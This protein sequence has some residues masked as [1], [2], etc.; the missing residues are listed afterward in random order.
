MALDAAS[1]SAPCLSRL[2]S[3]EPAPSAKGRKAR[4]NIVRRLD[5]EAWR[6]STKIEALLEELTACRTEVRQRGDGQQRPAGKSQLLTMFQLLTSTLPLSFLAH[7]LRPSRASCFPSLQRFL[8]SSNGG[9]SA[10]ACGTMAGAPP[11]SSPPAP[12][13]HDSLSRAPQCL[14][15]APCP[16][17][18][19][20]LDGRMQPTHRAAVIE[21]FNT[22]PEI[23]VFLISLKVGSAAI[24]AAVCPPCR[25]CHAH[26]ASPAQAGGLA[27]NLTAA[28]RVYIMDPWWNP[29]AE[30]QVPWD[31]RCPRGVLGW[32]FWP[33]GGSHRPHPLPP[34][35]LRQGYGPHPSA[36]A[37]SPSGGAA[38][39]YR[40][41]HREPH[42]PAA[43]KEAA[44]FREHGEAIDGP[45]P[46][47]FFLTHL[48]GETPFHFPTSVLR[49]A[50]WH[51]RLGLEP[52]DG[53]GPPILVLLTRCVDPSRFT[54][55][56]SI[57]HAMAS[58]SCDG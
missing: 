54:P 53:G 9:C 16:D 15:V 51:G 49:C 6:S 43:G 14:F 20:K 17:S 25:V 48:P 21:A 23:T 29:A 1:G 24:D 27:L 35:L 50:G 36:G 52:A 7:S 12:S 42:R 40:K 32:R 8:T 5:I 57:C 56:R 46:T 30:S 31:K 47:F 13:S 41:F 11:A 58:V 19:V 2:R 22:K 45:K 28:S 44:S 26:N 18:V 38:P 4:S 33:L 55:S 3:E 39:H 37:E 10:P 34:V